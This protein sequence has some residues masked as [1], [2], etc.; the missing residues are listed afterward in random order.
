[1]NNFFTGPHVKTQPGKLDEIS[2]NVILHFTFYVLLVVFA[3]PQNEMA[4][5]LH[6]QVGDCSQKTPVH[7]PLGQ[8]IAIFMRW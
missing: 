1:M 7:T 5:G 3:K 6:Q 4:T 2:F 8:V